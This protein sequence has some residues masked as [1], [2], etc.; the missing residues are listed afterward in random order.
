MYDVLNPTVS[1]HLISECVKSF[2]IS[3][4][5]TVKLYSDAVGDP[6]L[7]DLSLTWVAVS[8]ATH[9]DKLSIKRALSQDKC[10]LTR[11][12]FVGG[13]SAGKTDVVYSRFSVLFIQFH[14]GTDAQIREFTKNYKQ[15][16][17]HLWCLFDLWYD[18]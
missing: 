13:Q 18:I 12:A 1:L 4:P 11:A 3:L 6:L 14:G 5:C 9:W 15:D 16:D 2:N 10:S 7:T 17:K 8:L